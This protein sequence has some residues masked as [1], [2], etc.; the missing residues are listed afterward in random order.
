M[1]N[2]ALTRTVN[3]LSLVLLIAVLS[4]SAFGQA[5]YIPDCNDPDANDNA[6]AHPSQA[7]ID[8]WHAAG[9]PYYIGHAEPT[10]KF[11]SNA[12]ASG[13]NMQWKFKLPATDPA[14]N[15]AGTSV[16][17]FELDSAHWVSMSLCDPNSFPY[18]PCAFNSDT[19]TAAGAGS[20]LLEL[21]F[22]PPGSPFTGSGSCSTT[23]WC[24]LLH[25]NTAQQFTKCS[26]PTTAAFVTTTGVP[27]GPKLF[28]NNGDAIVVTLHDTA[29]GLRADVSDLTTAG[30][31]FM[32]ASGA[33]G[34]VHNANQ[35]DCTTTAFDFHPEYMTA[36]PGNYTAWTS[37]NANVAFDFEIGHFELCSDSTCTTNP[38]PAE[39]G[40][41]SCGTLRGIGGCTASD[42]DH[43]GTSYLADWPNGTAAFPASVILGSPNDQGVG[44]LS[45]ATTG[46]STYNQGYKTIQFRTTEGTNGAFYPFY[47]QAGTGPSCVFNFG[48]DILGT[49]TNDF[50]QAAQYGTTIQNPCFPATAQPPS[51]SKV[52]APAT[53]QV[54][55]IT[56]LTF[57]I[58]NP[59]AGNL[60]G[61]GF[62]D[63]LPAG[64]VV[65][66]VGSNSCGGTIT[67]PGAVSIVLTGATVPP[68]PC[69]FSVT[70]TGVTP[71]IEVNVSGNVTSDESVDGNTASASVI[72]VMPPTI[73]KSFT[74]TKIV[75]GGTSALSF[76]V[77]NPNSFAPLP[78]VGFTDN[79]PAGVVVATPNGLTGSCGGGTITATAGSPTISLSGATLANNASCAFSVNVTAPEGIYV[80]ATGAV[81]STYGSGKPSN[82][83]MLFVATPP[84]LSKSF[85]LVSMGVGSTTS[86]T[87]TLSNPNHILTLTA[88]QFSDTLPAGLVVATPNGANGTC[89]GQII[90]AVE[91]TNLISLTSVALGPQA[92]CTLTV[93]VTA[94]GSA[95]GL[96]INTT[97]TVTSTE[98]TPGLAA[99]ATIFIDDPYQVSYAANLNVGDSVVN[100]TNT[101]S[102]GTAGPLGQ[103]S[104]NICVN[105]YTFDPAEELISCCSCS[106]TPNG[107]QSISVRGSLTSNPLT[108]TIPT[109]VVIKL[110]ASTG[111]CNAAT[112]TTASLALGMRAWGT[113]L[114]ALPTAP[115]TYGVTEKPF[116]SSSLSEAELA[117]LTAFCGLVQANGSGFGICS[118][119][120]AGGLGANK[121]F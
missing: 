37:L 7:V 50:S 91:G 66:S 25:I 71:G 32:V 48:N 84:N 76:T 80:N 40:A 22:F 56:V 108:P 24:V 115:V 116:L 120:S 1:T 39:Q 53:I 11:F 45:A 65:A 12:G 69:N 44:P 107:L 105:V 118:G 75:P 31:G 23:Q 9:Y 90:T 96:L 5:I 10:V 78:G 113:T 64:L 16:A 2:Q 58:T 86:L 59:N 104:G 73:S 81:F 41:K 87:F 98:A 89:P 95:Q 18:G 49:T 106:V 4:P 6:C 94:N 70:V 101:G 27:A 43:D 20:A 30:T 19:N 57:T 67:T 34:F 55:S 112:V 14:P 82:Q 119:C 92:S 88:L 51:I 79:L 35:T 61:V 17:N 102:S 114:H 8:A 93:N 52:F 42:K 85:G 47:S 63:T 21:Q 33:N 72:V 77:T 60:T 36:A 117:H 111:P 28:L 110:L 15:Q 103:I 97:S 62:T 74:P 3:T 68:G 38:D 29:S 13:N 26:E 83:A 99:S 54:N 46:G 121:N 109:S 100:V